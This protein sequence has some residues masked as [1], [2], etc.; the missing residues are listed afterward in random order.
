MRGWLEARDRVDAAFVA[1]AVVAA[2]VLIR[3][4]LGL[5]FFADEWAFIESRS[6]T[7]PGTWF[8]PH[9]E[10][11][12]TLPILAYRGLVE[13]VGLGSYVPYLALLVALH[14]VVAGLVYVLVRRR[15]PPLVGLGAAAI[16]LFLGSGFE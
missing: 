11:W 13:T 8:A 4:G 15:N 5:T 1:L 7:D 6:L 2:G 3:L 12:S 10:H 14:V 16:V 9:N